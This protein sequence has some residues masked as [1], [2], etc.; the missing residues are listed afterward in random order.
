MENL[1]DNLLTSLKIVY[2]VSGRKLALAQY[3]TQ[4]VFKK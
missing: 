4:T 2:Y 3:S 1:Q